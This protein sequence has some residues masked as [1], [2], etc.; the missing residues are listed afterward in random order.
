MD[1]TRMPQAEMKGAPL[2]PRMFQL[3]LRL[4]LQVAVLKES[5]RSG[6]ESA[7]SGMDGVV[8]LKALQNLARMH[9]RPSHEEM[10]HSQIDPA[11]DPCTRI[12]PHSGVHVSD[13]RIIPLCDADTVILPIA[14]HAL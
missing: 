1:D 7:R 12:S 11:C 10:L 5:D 9:C 14:E 4:C 8:G 2:L 6:W 13:F 3:Y